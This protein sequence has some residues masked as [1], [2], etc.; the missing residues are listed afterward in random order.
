[1]STAVP[2]WSQTPDELARFAS[3]Q[4]ALGTFMAE[5]PWGK[6]IRV[7]LGDGGTLEGEL[8]GCHTRTSAT[9]PI[10]HAATLLIRTDE[11]LREIDFL[12]IRRVG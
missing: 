12:D 5:Q 8:H 9:Y 10:H 7:E 4:Q 1:M 6:P 3:V 2:R 11:G